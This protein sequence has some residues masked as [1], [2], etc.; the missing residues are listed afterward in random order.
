MIS[1][2][3]S[4]AASLMLGASILSVAPAAHAADKAMIVLDASGS[5]WGQIGGKAKIEIAKE[6]LGT[7]LQGLPNDLELGLIAY[8]HREKGVCKDI[9]EMVKPAA[10]TKGSIASAVNGLSPKG[11]TPLSDSVRLAAE[12]L[13]YTEDKATVILITDG[14]ETCNADPCALATELEK[15][16]V[17]FTAHVIGFG[18]TAEQGKK[19]S[20]IA[21]R[22]GGIYRQASDAAD[23]SSALVETV[24][25]APAPK[26]EPKPAPK[27]KPA[28]KHNLQLQAMM[29]DT[30]ELDSGSVRWDVYPSEDGVRAKKRAHVSYGDALNIKLPAGEYTVITRVNKVSV[31]S[32]FTL[33][34]T[35]ALKRGINMNVGLLRLSAAPAE[36]ADINKNAR[37]DINW[38][39]K[40]RITGYGQNVA[41][42]PA[43]E[44][45]LWARIG[46]ATAE[47]TI[48]VKAGE[49]IRKTIVVAAGLLKAGAAYSGEGPR[50]ES[51]NLRLQVFGAK[52][53][54]QGKR[55][56]FETKYGK[57]GQF[58]L[59]PGKYVVEARMGL[60]TVFS[61]PFEI[62]PN[63]ATE[64]LVDLNAGVLAISAPGAYRIDIFGTKKNI[65]GKVKKYPGK[66]GPKYQVTMPAGEYNVVAIIGKD[67]KGEKKSVTVNVAAG[68]R[69]ETEVK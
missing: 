38:G 35:E 34:D 5:M 55:K 15:A 21:E 58:L 23:L 13:R 42:I 14:I 51:G 27:P 59:A 22:T 52:K 11:K 24:A 16:G 32:V 61:E 37:I 12:S 48:E 66:Y 40:Q 63:E 29:S 50:V 9:E 3:V 57:L 17:D 60:A 1:R 19:V 65:Q 6:T 43:G 2:L 25:A 49:T 8:G 53:N 31:E 18:L 41:F 33:S 26:P 7:V 62:T 69:T 45:R 68:E 10:G 39:K 20:C 28:F 30:V 4:T 64:V 47:E 56:R 67:T 44:A 46:K 54:L 36:G